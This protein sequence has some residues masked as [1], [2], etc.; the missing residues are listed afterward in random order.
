MPRGSNPKRNQQSQ[1]YK[2][3]KT[4][5]CNQKFSKCKFCLKSIHNNCLFTTRLR[6][7]NSNNNWECDTCVHRNKSDSQSVSHTVREDVSI[8]PIFD[9]NTL[10]SIFDINSMVSRGE[11]EDAGDSNEIDVSELMAM[12]KYLTCEEMHDM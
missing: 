9:A 4:I 8:A 12:D 1:C 7:R 2:C 3:H 10:N 11:S 5:H 6:N